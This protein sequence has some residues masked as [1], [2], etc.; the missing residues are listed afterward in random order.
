M[1]LILGKRFRVAFVWFKRPN[2]RTHALNL[3]EF[4][5]WDKACKKQYGWFG[6]LTFWQKTN[7]EGSYT[8]LS[9]HWPHHLCW[10]WSIWM[11]KRRSVEWDGPKRFALVI[12]REYKNYLFEFFG[13][14]ISYHWQESD[15]MIG[16]NHRKSG[17]EIIW[18]R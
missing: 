2:W 18:D 3:K 10:D 13:Y 14:Y 16:M 1:R 15:Y 12:D 4:E 11:G 7:V 5:K 9:R 6:G 8:L 17:P